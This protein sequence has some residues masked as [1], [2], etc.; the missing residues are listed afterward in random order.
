MLVGIGTAA[1][2]DTPWYVGLP[3]QSV[4]LVAEAGSVPE[5]SLDPLLRVRQDEIYD[6][7]V[8][9][10]DLATLWRA[11]EF[12]SVAADVDPWFEIGPDGE[13][14][15]AVLL[16]YRVVPSPRVAALHVEG[17]KGAERRAALAATG[18]SLGQT[19]REDVDLDA[20]A[21]RT[22]AA[23]AARGWPEAKVSVETVAM[24]E[25]RGRPAV[26][27]I[28]RVEPG[29]AHRLASID[30][31]GDA[32]L[33]EPRMRSIARGAGVAV[34]Q[35]FT[36]EAAGRAQVALRRD[37]ARS[38]TLLRPKDRTPL[39]P[40]GARPEARVGA[41]VGGDAASGFTV[42]YRIDAGP[43][44]LLAVDG[45]AF[46]GRAK[47]RDALAI[48]ERTRLTRG[49]LDA[50]EL[51][52]VGALQERGFYDAKAKLSLEPKDNR[53]QLLSIGV[54]KG[55]RHVLGGR[56]SFGAFA[57]SGG[58]RAGLDFRGNAEISDEALRAVMEQAS[59]EVIRLGWITDDA[60]AIGLAAATELYRSQG[61][62]A[63]TL[64]VVDRVERPRL[65]PW[66]IPGFRELGHLL[67]VEP[68][69]TVGVAI[70]VVEGPQ[71]RLSEFDVVGAATEVDLGF[72][73][74]A[75]AEMIGAPVSPQALERLAQR[76]MDVHR[77]AGFLEVDAR[78]TRR[79][80]DPARV[81]ATIEVTTGDRVLLRS[82]VFR[83]ARDT[84]PTFLRR[85]AATR[86]GE[87]LGTQEIDAIRKSLYDL[88]VFRSVETAVIGDG[89]TRDLVVSLEERQRNAYE[90]GAGLSTDQGVRGYARY[91]RNN[92]FGLAHRGELFGLVGLDYLTDSLDDWRLDAVNPEWRAAATYTAP[93][94]PGASQQVVVDVLLREQ[95]QERA[96]R[97]ERSAL[98][99][100]FDA[101]LGALQKTNLRVQLRSEARRLLEV[102]AGVFLPDEPWAP[103]VSSDTK[104]SLPTPW[105]GQHSL[106]ALLIRDGRDDPAAPTRG[107]LW[108]LR[109]EGSPGL[110]LGFGDPRLVPTPFVKTE[111]R[112][113][114]WWALGAT[115][116]HLGGQ[117][118]HAEE[119]DARGLA[120][121]DR[122][123]LGGTG[124]LR[125]FRRDGV[126][127]RN[128]VSQPDLA[129]PDALAPVIGET[130]RQQPTR[131]VNTGG[132]TRAAATAEWIVPLTSLGMRSWEGYA[133]TVWVDVGNVW[134]LAGEPTDDRGLSATYAP[135]VRWSP[136]L[137]LRVS[138]P[139]GPLQIDLAANP[140]AAF[141]TGARGVLLRELWN[142]PSFR[143]HL[144]LGTLF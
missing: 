12:S 10:E 105:R 6:P 23:W 74:A 24:G 5:A 50:A 81:G 49:F 124:S 116:V 88:G 42:I 70:D 103:L 72:V 26:D 65:S 127:P 54:E 35:T 93:R 30:F 3:V 114:G 38:G 142:E 62:Q 111:A 32:V 120:L 90:L 118:D 20:V 76:I 27:V 95:I 100:S 99:L 83:G 14:I 59:P 144:S 21:T 139:V 11:G 119:L 138:T 33:S 60:L 91:T 101:K 18:V 140:D 135:A 110:R 34:G 68:P 131:W 75:R 29:F 104:V 106:Q 19:W 67:H 89:A 123:R 77:E 96:W 4:Q 58:P 80:L 143:G 52:I 115:T 121:E 56:F 46:R 71:T 122:Y 108:S 85:V 43:E 45:F 48:D 82:V 63:A 133:A 136:G 22:T 15:P 125:G 31:D 53:A 128:E 109:V 1:A 79:A 2:A 137:G 8:V 107:T 94:F 102:D 132:D 44:L 64:A 51:R 92:L 16:R 57:S 84:R 61:Y 112:G 98:S 130:L 9:R 69:V 41:I 129:W 47:V 36:A 73:A 40:G 28:V 17:L 141:A 126:G 97:L 117:F 55:A 37:I 13:S 134:L 7:A 78:V 66:W 87:P 39:R 25:Q 86:P 113:A